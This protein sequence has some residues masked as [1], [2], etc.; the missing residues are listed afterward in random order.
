[1]TRRPGRTRSERKALG[2]SFTV[3]E[4]SIG[5]GV[6]IFLGTLFGMSLGVSMAC[7]GL[8]MWLWL[9]LAFAG[10]IAGGIV[11]RRFP[12]SLEKHAPS[13]V[14]VEEEPTV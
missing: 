8:T 3:A 5:V 9:V 14:P 2:E 10:A 1:M 7:F 11:G 4:H 6:G 13:E 12:F